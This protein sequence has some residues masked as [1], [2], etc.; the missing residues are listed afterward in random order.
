MTHMDA[1]AVINSK[2]L[3]TS[4][5][6]KLS[7]YRHGGSNPRSLPCPLYSSAPNATQVLFC[8]KLRE[9]PFMWWNKRKD[10]DEDEVKEKAEMRDSTHM[11]SQN[12]N[13]LIYHS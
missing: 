8:E 12:V 11:H 1:D 7:D 3:R 6:V 2:K 13:L 10:S 4:S 9:W 5:Y